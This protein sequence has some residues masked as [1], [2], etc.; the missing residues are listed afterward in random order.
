MILPQHH[1]PPTGGGGVWLTVACAVRGAGGVARGQAPAGEPAGCA[2]WSAQRFADIVPRGDARPWGWL[3]VDASSRRNRECSA[4]IA[5]VGRGGAEDRP[6]GGRLSG[7][8]RG[9]GPR[10]A[11]ELP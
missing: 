1:H 7:P 4:S 10:A 3:R 8:A 11:S 2:G 5:D 6:V 9:P